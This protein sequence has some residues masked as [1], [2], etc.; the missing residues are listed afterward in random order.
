[1]KTTRGFLSLRKIKKYYAQTGEQDDLISIGTIGLIKGIS[2]FDS[3]KGARLST[4]AARCIENEILMYFRGRRKQSQEISLSETI[5]GDQDGNSL[6][7]MDVVSVDDTMLDDISA[8]DM[9]ALL[10]HYIEKVLDERE[11]KIVILRYGLSG[12]A[13]L[14]QRE[15]AEICGISRS[16]VSRIEKKA[17][18]KLRGCFEENSV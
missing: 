8:G 14:T 13:Q 18:E 16:Y 4:Y 7:L 17:L 9:Q 11:Q 2:S 10:H 15:T 3:G 1:L 5:E 6:S 12:N